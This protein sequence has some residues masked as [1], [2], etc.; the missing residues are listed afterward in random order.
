[1]NLLENYLSWARPKT[2][3]ETLDSDT[4]VQSRS[5]EY[6][7]EFS[8]YPEQ[9]KRYIPAAYR[10]VRGHPELRLL[11]YENKEQFRQVVANAAFRIQQLSSQDLGTTP[12]VAG[13]MNAQSGAAQGEQ[14]RQQSTGLIKEDYDIFPGSAH[15]VGI[16]G[17]GRPPERRVD[18]VRI[19]SVDEGTFIMRLDGRTFMGLSF[20]AVLAELSQAGFTFDDARAMVEEAAYTG[21]MTFLTSYYD[22]ADIKS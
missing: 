12:D 8:E 22:P 13:A 6:D 3:T 11:E 4:S 1:M 20:P 14:Q 10:Q 5:S 21:E 18:H 9:I 17:P 16:P 7:D 2:I 15:V 19:M